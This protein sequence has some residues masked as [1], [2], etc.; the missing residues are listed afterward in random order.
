MDKTKTEVQMEN[1]KIIKK[2]N[3]VKTRVICE[4]SDSYI[5]WTRLFTH[6]GAVAV[7]AGASPG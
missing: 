3:P 5:S 7:V 2:R 1:T 6:P 4:T